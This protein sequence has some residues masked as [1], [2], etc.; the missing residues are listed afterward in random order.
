MKMIKKN[1]VWLFIAGAI[2]GNIFVFLHGLRLGDQISTFETSISELKE[3]KTD[4]EKK[5]YK[6]QYF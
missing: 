6:S 5:V 1:I 2:M 3:Q 4:L